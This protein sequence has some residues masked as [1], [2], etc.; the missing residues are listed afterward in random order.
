MCPWPILCL[1]KQRITVFT[2]V[3][4]VFICAIAFDNLNILVLSLGYLLF[5][6][7]K[8]IIKRALMKAVNYKI[9][10]FLVS[11]MAPSFLGAAAQPVPLVTKYG[12]FE[13]GINHLSAPRWVVFDSSDDVRGA[14]SY[15]KGKYGLDTSV[16]EAP[17]YGF[18]RDY[19]HLPEYEIPLSVKG[20]NSDDE[21]WE[22]LLPVK[23]KSSSRSSGDI[24]FQSMV[25]ADDTKEYK[26]QM[27]FVNGDKLPFFLS[28]NAL[29]H[30]RSVLDEYSS[31]GFDIDTRT[32]IFWGKNNEY[33]L[34]FRSPSDGVFWYSLTINHSGGALKRLDDFD[35]L[36]TVIAMPSRSKIPFVSTS[37]S[38]LKVAGG[39]VGEIHI[40][41][42][43]DDN[44][45]RFYV[46]NDGTHE[47]AWENVVHRTFWSELLPLSECCYLVEKDGALVLRSLTSDVSAPD[48]TADSSAKPSF[49]LDPALE[50]PDRW[51]RFIKSLSPAGIIGCKEGAVGTFL[52]NTGQGIL[53]A[54]KE[55]ACFV[56]WHNPRNEYSLLDAP[57]DAYCFL[58]D[59]SGDTKDFYWYVPSS[60]AVQAERLL[61]ATAFSG[62]V[63]EKI[64]RQ[65]KQLV[66]QGRTE[67]ATELSRDS[68]NSAYS[69]LGLVAGAAAATVGT[70]SLG[71]ATKKALELHKLSGQIKRTGDTNQRVI[72]QR[73]RSALIKQITAFGV[74]G[75]VGMI[76]AGVII[77]KSKPMAS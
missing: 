64:V 74:V 66:A 59:I 75:V 39:E 67:L 52:L 2:S 47:V 18:F 31:Y 35:F 62:D 56:G 28:D 8:I 4:L 41:V 60:L 57:K 3:F 14:L 11:F 50:N 5:I 58:K 54:Q 9:I 23:R 73:K 51:K 7:R 15:D 77:K 22:I 43:R 42:R 21:E 44:N 32:V 29:I 13:L 45:G 19:N 36:R 55:G 69:S 27:V 72:L 61:R 25:S 20:L 49:V 70:I 76:S 65:A 37:D 16:L 1:A 34:A 63:D 10:F 6:V 71:F 17:S 38:F 68:G 26:S 24:K 33:Y 48:V 53:A 46:L 30:A 40:P 12:R